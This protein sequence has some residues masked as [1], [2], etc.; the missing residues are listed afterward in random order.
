MVQ[1]Q[2]RI[3]KFYLSR[4]TGSSRG[5]VSSFGT[6]HPREIQIDFFGSVQKFSWKS[7]IMK[8]FHL[9][10]V[11][12]R[13]FNYLTFLPPQSIYKEYQQWRCHMVSGVHMLDQLAIVS[14]LIFVPLNMQVVWDAALVTCSSWGSFIFSNLFMV[15]N[16]GTRS[17]HLVYWSKNHKYDFMHKRT[18]LELGPELRYILRRC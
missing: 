4:W 13:R 18:S 8:C 12:R 11:P 10:F 9:C 15:R 6:N 16:R 7:S 14:T 3:I 2:D 5:L 1:L 17:C